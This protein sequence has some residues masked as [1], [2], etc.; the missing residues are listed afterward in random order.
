MRCKGKNGKS[1]KPSP[2]K[3]TKK[4]QAR[5]AQQKEE[6]KKKLE[7]LCTV[8]GPRTGL[9]LA[10]LPSLQR[11][12]KEELRRKKLE[13]IL[14]KVLC[15][16]LQYGGRK[17]ILTRYLAD[18]WVLI[19][20]TPPPFIL[21]ETRVLW[22][23]S[24]VKNFASIITK[25]LLPGYGGGMFGPGIYLGELSKAINYART[26]GTEDVGA[27]LLVK[28]TASLGKVYQATDAIQGPIPGFNTIMGV[29]GKTKSKFFS[30]FLRHN[31][32]CLK[33]AS[34]VALLEVFVLVPRST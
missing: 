14:Q 18:Q 19:D 2:S 6:I 1:Q 5:T 30:G 7:V 31:E 4:K 10:L 32:W 12:G 26:Q 33:S 13:D 20:P 9:R 11:Q 24:Y 29:K 23:G 27:G 16:R 28:C 17:K 3:K 21:E 15:E 25:G 8:S 22:H 34:Q